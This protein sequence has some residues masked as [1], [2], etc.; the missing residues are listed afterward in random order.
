MSWL[1]FW[2]HFCKTIQY[3]YMWTYKHAQTGQF[4]KEIITLNYVRQASYKL[5]QLNSVE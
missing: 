5:T 2:K 3:L 1:V 4:L